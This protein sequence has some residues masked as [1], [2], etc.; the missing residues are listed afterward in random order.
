LSFTTVKDNTPTATTRLFQ[1]IDLDRTLFD[2]VRFVEAVTNEINKSEPGL[3]VVLRDR[4]EDAYRNDRTFFMFRQL[5]QDKGDDWVEKLVA[6]VVTKHGAD[7]FLMEGARRRLRQAATLTSE[8]PAW[9]ILTYGDKVDQM[10]KLRI[11]GLADAPVYITRTPHKG[12]VI[13]GWV[14]PM[15]GFALPEAFGGK[16]VDAL[17]LEDDKL[18]AFHEMPLGVVGVWLTGQ[19]HAEERLVEEGL[20]YVHVAR[21]LHES[22]EYLR[23][24]SLEK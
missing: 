7:A 9:G 23:S 18:A 5:R 19:P 1:L 6:K 14:H 22:L 17:S 15:G 13:Q 2:T 10:M 21:T 4:F 3:G 16:Q 8:T 12:S 24:K 20:E 11:I